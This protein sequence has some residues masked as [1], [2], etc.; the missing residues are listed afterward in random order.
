M[1]GPGTGTV[2]AFLA[3][4]L[5]FR[6]LSYTL[7]GKPVCARKSIAD[8][9]LDGIFRIDSVDWSGLLSVTLRDGKK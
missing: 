1:L 8:I 3:F 9:I 5:A 7:L 6:R 2:L 4:G